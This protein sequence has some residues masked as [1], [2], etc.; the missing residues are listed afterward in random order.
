MALLRRA[1]AEYSPVVYSCSLGVEGVLLVDLISTHVPQIEIV[2]LDTG[3][4]P[5][6]T[7]YLLERLE[8][9]Y[10]RRIRVVTPDPAEIAAL[11]SKQGINGFFHSLEARKNCCEVRKVA[12]FP[13]RHR[14]Q[15]RLDHRR[16]PRAVGPRAQPVPA[17]GGMSSTSSTR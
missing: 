4:L 11:V 12:P 10:G 13:P 7:Y 5:E 2:T 9:R 3:R 6:E 15:A 14:R 1:V 16:A 17:S 8:R